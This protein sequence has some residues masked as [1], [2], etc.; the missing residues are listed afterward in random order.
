MLYEIIL[1][2]NAAYGSLVTISHVTSYVTDGIVRQ[3]QCKLPQGFIVME[4]KNVSVKATEVGALQSRCNRCCAIERGSFRAT[5][6]PSVNSRRLWTPE[7]DYGVENCLS[8]DPDLSH[9]N[10][11]TTFPTHSL[12]LLHHVPKTY[13]SQE[14]S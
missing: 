1:S 3:L 14:R 6:N 8:V 9:I 12:I 10:P 7:I 2:L 4:G 13:G 5:Y 11:F